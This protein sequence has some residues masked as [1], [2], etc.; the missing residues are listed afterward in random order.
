LFNRR[1][2]KDQRE[3]VSADFVEPT[4]ESTL[5]AL[6]YGEEVAAINER[7]RRFGQPVVQVTDGALPSVQ[8]GLTGLAFSGGGIRSATVNFGVLQGFGKFAAIERFDYLSTVSGGGFAGGCLS[9]TVRNAPVSRNEVI[10]ISGLPES[11]YIDRGTQDSNGEWAVS[12]QNLRD[13]GG[14]L[15]VSLPATVI[16]S[17]HLVTASTQS[18]NERVPVSISMVD[19]E[20]VR[21]SKQCVAGQAWGIF[22]K[23]ANTSEVELIVAEEQF[24]FAFRRPPHRPESIAMQHLREHADYLKPHR[25]FAG[26]RIPALFIVGFV[27]NCFVLLPWLLWF[28]VATYAVWSSELQHALCTNDSRVVLHTDDFDGNGH[29]KLELT[30]FLIRPETCLKRSGSQSS[31]SGTEAWINLLN[32]PA[33]AHVDPGVSDDVDA[34]V[35]YAEHSNRSQLMLKCSGEVNQASV[36][37]GMA[38]FDDPFKDSLEFTVRTWWSPKPPS[39]FDSPGPSRNL[40]A[41]DLEFVTDP[42]SALEDAGFRSVLFFVWILVVGMILYPLTRTPRSWN[43]RDHITRVVFGLG[44]VALGVITAVS[45]QPLATYYFTSA[46]GAPKAGGFLGG[47]GGLALAISTLV[48]VIGALLARSSA[49]KALGRAL[50]MYLAAL[51]GFLTL[52]LVASYFT[53]WL[54]DCNHIPGITVLRNSALGTWLQA[55]FDTADRF[56]P[57]VQLSSWSQCSLEDPSTELAL[58][59]VVSGFILWGI[60]RV[61]FNVNKTSFPL[62]YRDRLSRAFCFNPWGSRAEHEDPVPVAELATHRGPFH[63]LN[64][65]LNLPRTKVGNLRGR[66]CDFF[67]VTPRRVGSQLTGYVSTAEYADAETNF[68][69][70]SVMA[71]SGAAAAPTMGVYTNRALVFLMALLNVRLDFWAHNPRLHQKPPV[72]KESVGAWYLL[73]EMFGAL[74]EQSRYVN[75][76]DGGHLENLG[77]YE[78]IRRRCRIIVCSDC[79]A[80]EQMMFDGLADLIR[81]VRIDM[82]VEI[83]IDVKQIVRQENGL[84]RCHF[85]CG[86]INYPGDAPG[87]VQQGILIYLKASITGDEGL[88]I[89]NY[90]SDHPSFPNETTADQFFDEPQFEAYR[91]LGQHI[92]GAFLESA[93]AQSWLHR[94]DIDVAAILRASESKSS[95]KVRSEGIQARER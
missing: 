9:T 13:Q 2:Q 81:L 21:W 94:D 6:V 11:A 36:Q 51:A 68:D 33:N 88:Y 48:A 32:V 53:L 84:S 63:L 35:K 76:S 37:I 43:T 74:D 42:I 30:G 18:G 38:A 50:L 44:I 57:F 73:R 62:F 79:Q 49:A 16:S 95:D 90:R 77:V 61:R 20:G 69:L 10:W 31:V 58:L 92:A 14:R 1:V 12:L 45:M 82:G 78:L 26:L 39:M 4:S 71:I 40:D 15:L 34:C 59:F 46:L 65:T 7:R 86:R 52:W 17:E 27:T 29:Y 25:A 70:S 24:P 93:V 64:T 5:S 87:E 66:G 89:D 60:T 8:H 19:Q 23:K 56:L 55:A 47:A 3:N 41:D 91:S 83:D 85:A 22:I 28:A 67:I 80:D 72:K 75:L 54:L